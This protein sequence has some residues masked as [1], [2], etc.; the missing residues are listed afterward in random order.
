[1]KTLHLLRALSFTIFFL[2]IVGANAQ[3]GR[4][5]EADLQAQDLFACSEPACGWPDRCAVVCGV[6]AVLIVSAP[7]VLVIL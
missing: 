7:P 4:S 6:G 1:M 2:L 5:H 3:G